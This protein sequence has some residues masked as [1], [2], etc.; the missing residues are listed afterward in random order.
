MIEYRFRVP[1]AAVV[2]L[3]SYSKTLEYRFRVPT[4]GSLS[5]AV[6]TLYSYSKALEYP[7]RVPTAGQS[8]MGKNTQKFFRSTHHIESLDACMKH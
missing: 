7:F 2:T 4:A 5:A 6:F 8:Q 3:Y 1:S